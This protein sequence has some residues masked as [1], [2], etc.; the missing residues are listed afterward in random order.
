MSFEL[1]SKKQL[2]QQG[3]LETKSIGVAPLMAR[4]PPVVFVSGGWGRCRL[5]QKGDGLP[6]LTEQQKGRGLLWFIISVK[7]FDQT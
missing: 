6:T 2:N 4:Q 3:A 5:A 7:V 1:G